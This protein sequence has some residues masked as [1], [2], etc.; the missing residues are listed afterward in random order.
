MWKPCK[1]KNKPSMRLKNVPDDVLYKQGIPKNTKRLVI[2][3]Y[4]R[5][6][7]QFTVYFSSSGTAD[8]IILHGF[9]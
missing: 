8:R 4:V 1:G 3:C 5:N 2:F 6:K 9:E 7:N